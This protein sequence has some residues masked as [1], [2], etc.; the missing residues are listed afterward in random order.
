[1]D[2]DKLDDVVFQEALEMVKPI[3]T[4][5]GGSDKV[6]KGTELIGEVKRKI[7]LECRPKKRKRP[8][9]NSRP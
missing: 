4:R 7:R 1:M 5:L 8:Q 3:Y 9:M 2:I 6:A